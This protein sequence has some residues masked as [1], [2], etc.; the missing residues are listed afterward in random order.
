MSDKKQ[1]K[2]KKKQRCHINYTHRLHINIKK[3]KNIHITLYITKLT[4]SRELLELMEF[5]ERFFQDV[6]PG[7]K[8]ADNSPSLI[9]EQAWE[10][11]VKD[12][13]T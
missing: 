6:S 5:S 12:S 1:K 11:R 7:R 4:L 8:T 2:Q 3:K 10:F 13:V 9:T